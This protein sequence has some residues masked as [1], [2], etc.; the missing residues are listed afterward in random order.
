VNAVATRGA[1]RTDPGPPAAQDRPESA[2]TL[3]DRALDL[4]GSDPAVAVSTARQ[5]LALERSQRDAAARTRAYRALG[6]AAQTTGNLEQARQHLRRAVRSARDSGDL[7]SAAEARMSLS[8]VLLG[9]GLTGQALRQSA[10]AADVL[11]GLSQHRLRAQRALVLQRC[12]RFV[13]ALAV[14]DDVIPRL[15]RAG[16]PVWEAKARTNRGVL[17][18][19]QGR[20]DDADDDLSIAR[21]LY[22]SAGRLLDAAGTVWNLG[23]LARERGDVVLALERF[24]EADPVCD[25]HGH[26]VGLRL[27]DRAALLLSVGVCHEAHDLA[28]R[29]R[30]TFK[31]TGQAADLVESEILL[32]Q[33]AVASHDRSA[34]VRH[35]RTA[36]RL[37][38]RQGRPGWVLL[39]RHL[40][41]LSHDSMPTTGGRAVRQAEQIAQELD[42][43]CWPEAAAEARLAAAQLALAGGRVRLAEKIMDAM[44]PSGGREFGARVEVR[45][46]HVEAMLSERR[47]DV[48]RASR[49]VR[50]GLGVL[51]RHRAGLGASDLQAHVPALGEELAR[52]G[53]RLALRE[54]VA[55]TVLR[56]VERWRGQDL[57]ARPVRP[58]R[59]PELSAA[60]ERLRRATSDSRTA[61]LGPASDGRSRKV[62]ASCEREVVRLS[63]RSRAARWR[64]APAPPSAGELRA[65][66]ADRVLVEFLAV[67]GELV[68]VVLPGDAA[69]GGGPTLHRLGPIAAAADALEFLQFALARLATGRGSRAALGAAMSGAADSAAV[70]DACLL[71]PLR[72]RLGE[73]ALVIAPTEA[74]HAVPW[75]VLPTGR[76]VPIHVV[77][78]GAAWLAASDHDQRVAPESAAVFVTGPDVLPAPRPSAVESAAWATGPHAT[79]AETLRLLDGADVAH[80]A[81]HGTF[82]ADNPLLSSLRLA[83]GD[84]TVYDLEGLRSPPRRVVLASCHSAA[85]QVLPGNQLLGVAHAL[86]TLGSAGVVATTL[87]TPDAETAVLMSALH[88]GLAAGRPASEALFVARDALDLRSPSGYATGAGFDLYGR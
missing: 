66:L 32:A 10:Q 28:E 79:V 70:L 6:L 25:E 5:A 42:A 19:F 18:A 21:D 71:K 38:S 33:I 34:A 50:Q 68:A 29:A 83:D 86:L 52:L 87:P 41:L 24:D 3:A 14:Y 81:A 57:R 23:C 43:A 54:G 75:S 59:D 9:L 30:Q 61:E 53:L 35:A 37:A 62:V 85:A 39:A 78:S 46:R 56:E 27:M 82:R 17:H 58:P 22:A 80:I 84:L 4:V 74:L 51:A 55:G 45:R 31:E 11:R 15:H 13:E 72:R 73:A 16:D 47:G 77:R 76:R 40:E 63:R 88:D 20:L 12:G 48:A 2:A 36:R 49:A 65:A 44:G 8:F 67:D 26:F 60:V 1:D 69:R 64:P 7:T